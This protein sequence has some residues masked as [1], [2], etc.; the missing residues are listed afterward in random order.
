MTRTFTEAEVLTLARAAYREG[1]PTFD[2]VPEQCA[3]LVI[4]EWQK[5]W[6]WIKW[7]RSPDMNLTR[8]TR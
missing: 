4:G 2:I 3:R 6:V 8:T 5:G 7:G 1:N